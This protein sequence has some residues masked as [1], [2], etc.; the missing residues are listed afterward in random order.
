MNSPHWQ[1]FNSMHV[2]YGPQF[3]AVIRFVDCNECRIYKA[4]IIHC[5]DCIVAE[6]FLRPGLMKNVSGPLCSLC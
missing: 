5:A 6:S 4:L 1:S 3:I 2:Q